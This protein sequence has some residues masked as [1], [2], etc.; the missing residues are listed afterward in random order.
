MALRMHPTSYGAPTISGDM[1]TITIGKYCSIANTVEFDGGMQHNTRFVTT[2]PLWRVGV[3]KVDRGMC[4]GDIVVGN[5]VWIGTGAIIM[6]GVTIGDGAVVGAR[7]VVTRNVAPYAMV[8]GAP[9]AFLRWRFHPVQI[10]R[11]HRIAWWDW[12]EEKIKANAHLM[13]QE[14]VELFIQKHAVPPPENP[15]HLGN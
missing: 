6:S 1:N 11:L 15:Y 12:D 8:G 3:P 14:N 5:D 9:M 2:Y 13:L 10:D 7:T 4:K